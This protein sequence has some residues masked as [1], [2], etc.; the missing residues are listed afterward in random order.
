M[1]KEHVSVL[2]DHRE[3]AQSVFCVSKLAMDRHPEIR[4][5][6]VASNPSPDR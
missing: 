6:A 2:I 5:F 3:R 1:V 4:A